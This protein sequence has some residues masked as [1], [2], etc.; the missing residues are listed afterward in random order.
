MRVD[1]VDGLIDGSK[2]TRGYSRHETGVLLQVKI[3]RM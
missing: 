3:A 2:L 1:F